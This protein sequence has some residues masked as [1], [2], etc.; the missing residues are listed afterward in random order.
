[1]VSLGATVIDRGPW[2]GQ[3]QLRY[4]GPRPL[5]EDNSQR[6]KATTLAYLRVG[7]KVDKNLK[8][9]LDVFN[10]FDRR[11]S[12]VDYYYYASCLRG[13]P[14]QGVNDTHFHLVEPRSL[15]LSLAASF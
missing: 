10:L 14:A 5:V 2:F 4:F 13:E 3:F 6:S 15:R 1:M 11:G 8:L 12:D 7:Y 9:A